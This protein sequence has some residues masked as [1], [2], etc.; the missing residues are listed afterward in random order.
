MSNRNPIHYHAL[1]VKN[2][3]NAVSES[4]ENDGF[5]SPSAQLEQNMRTSPSL[6]SWIE[7]SP[8]YCY[9]EQRRS[10]FHWFK[11]QTNGI[12]GIPTLCK[13][14]RGLQ[15]SRGLANCSIPNQ[16]IKFLTL[17]TK[18]VSFSARETKAQ[19]LLLE[20]S[21]NHNLWDLWLIIN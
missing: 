4:L 16:E 8:G 17:A 14:F 19:T 5:S 20:V 1:M 7:T 15:T 12:I 13:F 9:W 11:V 2:L 18:K 6:A 10:Q 3:K 21:P